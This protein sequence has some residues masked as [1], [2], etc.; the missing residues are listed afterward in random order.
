M[1]VQRKDEELRSVDMSV[2]LKEGSPVHVPVVKAETEE[3]RTEKENNRNI[4]DW[5]DQDWDQLFQNNRSSNSVFETHILED[6]QL[7]SKVDIGY[8]WMISDGEDDDDEDDKE[9]IRTSSKVEDVFPESEDNESFISGDDDLDEDSQS[10]GTP[11]YD[12]ESLMDEDEVNNQDKEEIVSEWKCPICEVSLTDIE[13][14]R[15]H[16][17]QHKVSR[18]I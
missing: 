13:S 5:M 1:M 6:V 18:Y 12:S 7:D 15:D 9:D 16:L 4:G 10:D 14:L 8:K 11:E 17:V 2:S 3:E